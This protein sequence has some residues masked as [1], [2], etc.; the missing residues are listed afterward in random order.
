MFRPIFVSSFY[1]FRFF[2][3]RQKFLGL[4][5][6]LVALTSCTS[7]S[8]SP[9]VPYIGKINIPFISDE[10]KTPATVVNNQAR[11]KKLPVPASGF[12]TVKQGD[13]V[14]G[15]ANRYD[16]GPYNIISENQLISPFTLTEGQILKLVPRN[17][18]TVRLGDSLFSISK[19]Y[20]VSQFEIAELNKLEEPFELKVNQILQ[21][22]DTKDLSVFMITLPENQVL[23][24]N[25]LPGSA[26]NLASNS[27]T[28]APIKQKYFV[29]PALSSGD[30]FNWP[31]S[32]EVINQFGLAE[33]GVHND[34]VDIVAD[35][36]T[37]VHTTAPGTVAYIGEGLK[38]FGTLILVKHEGG[39]ISAY[40][41]LSQIL[42]QEGDVLSSGQAIGRVGQSG[43]VDTPT[44]HFEIRQNRT[45]VDP[46]S[47]I[48]S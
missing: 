28:I 18:H 22:P 40:A 41:H 11:L 23:A 43:R 34:G 47:I 1:I 42:V 44:L 48:K 2:S 7:I 12:I 14:F 5:A 26:A 46:S 35:L 15:L 27:G 3:N 45:P 9:K 13:T 33:R 29:A 39:F 19:Q 20:S 24:V 31:L 36:G 8:V 6:F 30:A 10:R 16:V 17:T 38:S 21:L 32:G 4:T 25:S 37:E